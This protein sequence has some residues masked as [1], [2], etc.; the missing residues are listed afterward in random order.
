[1]VQC[2]GRTCLNGQVPSK[3]LTARGEAT[4]R[5]SILLRRMPP[6]I[7]IADPPLSVYRIAWRLCDSYRQL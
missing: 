7:S 2:T 1:M 3:C 5:G 4:C 6:P